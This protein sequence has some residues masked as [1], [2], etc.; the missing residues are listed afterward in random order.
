MQGNGRHLL[1]LINDILDVAR[2]EAGKLTVVLELVPLDRLIGDI[3]LELQAGEARAEVGVLAEIPPQLA[4][5]RTDALKLK[6]MIINLV[7]NAVKFTSVGNVTI[8]VG[9]K[10]PARFRS[11]TPTKPMIELSGVR[12]SWDIRDRNSLFAWLAASANSC[13]A[14]SRRFATSSSALRCAMVNSAAS[15]S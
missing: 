8:S 1:T 14:V 5:L 6:Q 13:A 9:V 11:N 2:V 7:G 3:L 4:P 12:S 10:R 15:R